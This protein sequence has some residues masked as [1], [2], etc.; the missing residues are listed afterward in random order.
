MHR[1]QSP[2]RRH[3]V[4]GPVRRVLHQVCREHDQEQ[5]E[6]E[7]VDVA[8]VEFTPG[9]WPKDAKPLRYIALRLTPLQTE[10]FAGVAVRY[11]AVVSNRR[12]LTPA[13]VIEST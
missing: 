11:H 9:V 13:A 6:R 5:R 8:E 4:V 1:V 12:E 7:R 10:L 2:Q 3:L